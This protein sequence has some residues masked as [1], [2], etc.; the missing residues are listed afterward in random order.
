MH[1]RTSNSFGEALSLTLSYTEESR[2]TLPVYR[3]PR[4]ALGVLVGPVVDV[5]RAIL[6]VWVAPS[7]AIGRQRAPRTTV[8]AE[9]AA[10]EANGALAVEAKVKPTGS[11]KIP[12]GHGGRAAV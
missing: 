3:S 7:E 10:S 9:E 1:Q 2:H 4:T 6:L 12:R 8:F 11:L 5:H